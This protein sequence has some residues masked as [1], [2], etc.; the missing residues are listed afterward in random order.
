MVSVPVRAAPVLA[1]T[2]NVTDPLPLPADP[3]EMAIHG[4]LAA[5]VQLQPGL[6]ETAT[7]LAVPAAAPI[8]W[9]AGLIEYEQLAPAA[10]V[11][12]NVWP[13]IVSVPLRTTPVLAA[14]LKFT[15]PG[16]VPLAAEVTVIHGALLDADHAHAAVVDTTI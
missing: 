5:A 8:D 16:P 1:L 12:A 15:F 6:V 11:T 2:V 14:T 4:T 13:A 7:G 10:C 3:D 9:L